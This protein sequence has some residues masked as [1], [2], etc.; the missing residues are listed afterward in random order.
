M[1]RGAFGCRDHEGGGAGA[2][3][4]GKLDLARGAQRVGDA[5]DGLD[6]FGRRAALEIAAGNR[7]PQAVDAAIDRRQRW[8]CRP[9]GADGI[10]RIGTLHGIVGERQVSR[11][12][13]QRTEVIEAGDKREGAR[14]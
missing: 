7:N 10:L 3:G 13:C 14:T 4:L 11:R 9:V 8:L 5:R 1:Q 2:C 6:G 12:S